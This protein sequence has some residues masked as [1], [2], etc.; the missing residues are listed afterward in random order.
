MK[1]S[2]IARYYAARELTKLSSTED[3]V[4][5]L[6]QYACPG[7]TLA[8]PGKHQP[9]FLHEGRQLPL[10]RVAERSDLA[11]ETYYVSEDE[12]NISLVT[13]VCFDLPKGTSELHF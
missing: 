3:G 6:A 11:N 8:L 9:I 10:K 4:K 12:T 2:E 1:M 5:M 7:F 13:M